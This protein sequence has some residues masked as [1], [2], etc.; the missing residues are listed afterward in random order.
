[1]AYESVSGENQSCSLGQGDGRLGSGWQV[2]SSGR[3]S[4]C[5]P[6]VLES[7]A[8]WFYANGYTSSVSLVPFGSEKMNFISIFNLCVCLVLHHLCFAELPPELERRAQEG[9][10]V[11]G[12]SL[13][14]FLKFI[15]LVVS[16]AN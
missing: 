8:E 2:L 16:N 13:Y 3:L 11:E 7:L 5:T 10:L 14:T 1:M 15:N 6:D 9:S 12:T 4:A